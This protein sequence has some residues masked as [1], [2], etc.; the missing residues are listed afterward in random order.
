MD[1]PFGE[2]DAL[3][4]TRMQGLLLDLWTRMRTTILFVTHDIDEALYLADRVLVLRILEELQVPFA[5][6]RHAALTTQPNFVALKR[7]C[8]SLLRHEGDAPVLQ[9]LTPLGP[10]DV[11]PQWRFAT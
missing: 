4:R 10:P 11:T 3:T 2:L 8:L 9:R 1:E 5:R 7:R 6:P